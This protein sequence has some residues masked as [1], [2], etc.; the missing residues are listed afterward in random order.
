MSAWRNVMHRRRVER[1]LDAELRDHIE[2][3]VA[4]A[5]RAGDSE[6][7]VRRQIRLRSGGL[8]QAKEACRD[9]RRFQFAT[10]AAHDLR[11][12]WRALL[13]DRWFSSAAILTLALGI[14]ATTAIF[15]VVYGV[16]LKPLA[17]EE[18]DRLVVINHRAPGFNTQKLPQSDATYFTYR[19]HNEAFEDVGLWRASRVSINR[20]TEPE[21]EQALRVTSGLLGILRVQPQLGA[22][23]REEDT[24]PGGANRTLLTHGYWQRAFGADPAIVGRS[25]V[26]EGAP[27]EVAGVLPPSFHFL[28]TR[29]A[30]LLPLR[31][32]RT[33]ALTGPGFGD[34]AVARLKPGVTLAQANADIG[35]MIPLIPQQFPLQPGVTPEMWAGVGLAPNVA[36]LSDEVIGDVAGSLWILMSAVSVVLVMAW[37]NVANLLFVRAQNR[38]PEYAMRAALGASRRR[39]VSALLSETALLG[40]AGGILGALFAAGAI[41]ALRDLAPAQLP[42][43]DD[44]AVDGVVLGFTLV[45]SLVTAFLLGCLP[46]VGSSRLS[47]NQFKDAGRPGSDAPSRHRTRQLLAVSQ[48][49]LALV[50]VILAGLMIRTFVAMRHVN[51]GF[52]RPEDVQA[53]QI[54]IPAALVS[55]DEGVLRTHQAIAER[56][57]QVP[58][59][60]NVGLA[61]SIPM[62]SAGG[63]SPVPIEDHPVS[64]TPI[65]R[66]VKPVGPGYFET[67]GDAVVAGRAITWDDVHRPTMVALI[68]EN[69]AREYWGEPSRAIGKRLGGP[70]GTDKWM[71]WTEI[72]G[73]V[74]NEYL[75]G[76]NHPPPTTVYF[77]LNP[78]WITRNMAYVVRSS[79]VGQQGFLRELQ[80][81]VRQVNPSL[82]LVNPRTLAA[83]QA[84]SM[85]QTS[86]AMVMLVLAASVA[87]LLGIIGI[88]GVMRYIAAQRTGE[89]GIRMALGAQ[90]HVIRRQLLRNGLAL[91]AGGIVL[92][93]VTAAFVT[94]FLSTLLFGV[95]PTDAL[96]YVAAAVGT[97]AIGL[98]AIYLPARRASA[99]DPNLVLRSGA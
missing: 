43:I 63:A 35:R 92:G 68:S 70:G 18:A 20:G 4:E 64:G 47:F 31:P 42:R 29:A 41:M 22:L 96:T 99:V 21:S 79:R 95:A 73:V 62:A 49:A 3:E 26:I 91:I 44:I 1:E 78:Q 9:V 67:M 83:I 8:D 65:T 34:R 54:I 5:V 12:A 97:A 55:D 85:A 30:L 15:T 11:C 39:L 46:A 10:V 59:V 77:A 86:F 81:A 82:P 84:T 56:L 57:A 23:F 76:L 28:D 51:P 40:L 45:L 38:R 53:F 48:I 69:L 16:L 60:I 90:P 66:R 7:D 75:D 17:F 72:V 33:R 58:G 74:G 50:L 89:I 93:A 87:L 88:Y 94:R 19:D 14:G 13:K 36:A 98:L 61:G 71:A 2:R 37:V 24:V 27:Y 52:T 32:D 25:L 6:A 80:E